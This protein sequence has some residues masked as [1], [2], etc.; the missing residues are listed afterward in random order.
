MAV[1]VDAGPGAVISITGSTV[2]GD[3]QSVDASIS[4][5]LVV[6]SSSLLSGPVGSADALTC[7]E[8]IDSSFQALDAS[9]L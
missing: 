2:T 1:G 4:T 8:V 6:V 9:C 3:F 5:D 7:V